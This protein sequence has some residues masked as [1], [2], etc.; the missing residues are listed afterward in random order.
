MTPQ[1]WPEL[2]GMPMRDC[3]GCA[4]PIR[5][6]VVGTL[7]GGE[8][9][10]PV[11]PLPD[12]RGNVFARRIGAR[13]HGYVLSEGHGPDPNFLRFMPHAASCTDPPKPGPVPEEAQP[14]LFDLKE[15]TP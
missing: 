2:R 7:G 8:S 10:L 9:I 4:A 12:P 1:T 11:N 14:G 13:L 3:H 15:G 5:F 6:V